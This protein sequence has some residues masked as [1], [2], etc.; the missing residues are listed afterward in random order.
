MSKA[1]VLILRA[2][3]TNCN[4]E[5]A[6]AFQIAGA[7]TT[8]VH[9]NQLLRHESSLADYQVLVI[10]GGFSYG[11]D[12]GAGKI[13]AN[14][15]RLKL[16]EDVVKFVQNGG[17]IL[18]ICNGFQVLVKAG[19]LPEPANENAPEVTLT[20]NDSSRFE[21]RWVHLRV[22]PDIP[23]VFTR[24]I[25]E[26][27]LPVAHA[28]GKLVVEP[29]R[30]SEVKAALYYADPQGGMNVNYPDNPNGSVDNIA[31]LCD[32]SGRIFAL[33]PHPERH[34]RGTQHPQWTRLGIR[35]YGDGFRVFQNAVDWVI[36]S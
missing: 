9:V 23:C 34:V 4:I 13:L 5:T 8:T 19:F 27:Y 16:G 28:E 22:N 24:G 32:S 3:G 36:H 33:M 11:D 30:L 29:G 17:L 25:E 10:P 26:M 6:Y 7:D 1:R 2:P 14:E 18:G 21:C 35:D 12:V 20:T 31:G 15:M